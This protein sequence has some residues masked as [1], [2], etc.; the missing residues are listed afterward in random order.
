MLVLV[1]AYSSKISVFSKSSWS[2]AFK[3]VSFLLFLVPWN[4]SK[5]QYFQKVVDHL[6]FCNWVDAYSLEEQV[7]LNCKFNYQSIESLGRNTAIQ[8]L[9]KP[10]G[11]INDP[12]ICKHYLRTNHA[13]FFVVIKRLIQ[14][15][16]AI[17]VCT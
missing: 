4:L 2:L 9:W 16:S 11:R 15:L 14:L 10:K 13:P 3:I 6:V 7:K 8:T 17:D 12:V 5:S 1:D